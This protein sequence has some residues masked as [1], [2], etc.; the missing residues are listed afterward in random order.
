MTI[1]YNRVFR[2]NKR[3]F[4]KTISYVGLI[5]LSGIIIFVVFPDL[6]LN[7][8]IKHKILVSLKHTYPNSTV[9]ISDIDYNLWQNNLTGKNVFFRSNENTPE[10]NFSQ[11]SIRNIKW[12]QIFLKRDISFKEIKKA[13]LST[14]DGRIRFSKNGYYLA[15]TEAKVSVPDSVISIDSI[16]IRP[17]IN[18]EEFFAKS[19]YRK[20]RY[21]IRISKLKLVSLFQPENIKR[22][23][24][25]ILGVIIDS[26]SFNFLVNRDKD[27]PPNKPIPKMPNESLSVIPSFVQIDSLFITN[28]KIRYAERFIIGKKPAI[29]N[30]TNLQIKCYNITNQPGDTTIFLAQTDFMNAAPFNIK[31]LYQLGAKKINSNIQG[32]LGQLE[33]SKMNQFIETAE[34]TRIKSGIHHSTSFNLHLNDQTAAGSIVSAYEDLKIALLDSTT[35][36]EGNL[37]KLKSFMVNTLKLTKTN[38]PDDLKDKKKNEKKIKYIRGEKDTFIKFIW[39]SLRGGLMEVIGI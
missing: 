13:R 14:T 15:F 30:F 27:F 16:I 32:S 6:L 8:V 36:K 35:K 19:E 1:S 38:M 24:I 25:H 2:F 18:D 33:L 12:F 17:E 31:M 10:L 3:I 37:N 21:D 9:Y 26:A 20:T 7:K 29:I 34:D 39:F 22:K 23:E 28:S 11:L 5:I 4:K